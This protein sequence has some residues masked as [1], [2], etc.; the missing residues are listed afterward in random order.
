MPLERLKVRQIQ[1]HV[2]NLWNQN[3]DSLNTLVPSSNSINI[4]LQWWQNLENLTQGIP[5]EPPPFTHHLFTDASQRGFG[6]FLQ[7]KLAVKLAL[8]HFDIPP[9]SH[10]LVASD[11]TTISTVE[12]HNLDLFATRFNTKCAF[13]VSPTP[14]H[15]A[16]STDN[17]VMSWEGIFAYVFPPQLILNQVLQTFSWTRCC[18]LILVA[19]LWPKQIWFPTFQRLSWE[20]PILLPTNTD[21]TFIIRTLAS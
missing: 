20:Q 1:F 15:R 14:D 21:Q 11:N 10:I 5:L 3:R 8:F 9:R 4:L 12:H 16:L 7:D 18:C 19:L 6:A 13:F 2:S 17:L